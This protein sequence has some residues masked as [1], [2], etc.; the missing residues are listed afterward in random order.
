MGMVDIPCC[1][2]DGITMALRKIL[3]NFV[4]WGCMEF[5]KVWGFIIFILPE[6]GHGDQ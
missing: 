2:G 6:L 1:Y 4:I 3:N 5:R